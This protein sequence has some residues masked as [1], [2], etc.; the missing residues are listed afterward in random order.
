MLSLDFYPYGPE[1]WDKKLEV[2]GL[3]SWDYWY[4]ISDAIKFAGGFP[5]GEERFTYAHVS[6]LILVLN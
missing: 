1:S 2:E 5:F 6:L 3:T 4:T